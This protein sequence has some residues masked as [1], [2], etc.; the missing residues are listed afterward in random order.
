MSNEGPS[1]VNFN[2]LQQQLADTLNPTT[3]KQQAKEIFANLL[4]GMGVPYFTERLKSKL[5]EDLMTKLTELMKDPDNLGKN[6]MEFAKKVF[7]EKFLEP[8]KNALLD[9][10]S[11]FIPELKDIDL[12]KASLT[13]IQ[14]A[15][16]KGIITKMKAK[17]PPEI[18]DALPENFTRDDIL[19]AVKGLAQD[20]ALE[21]A[22]NNLPPEAYA[23]LER[24][25]DILTDPAKISDFV[26]GKLADVESTVKDNFTAVKNQVQSR[27]DDVKAAIKGKIDEATEGLNGKLD[28]LRSARDTAKSNW[29]DLKSQFSDQFK[30]AKAKLEQYKA[31]NP[32][33]TAEDLNPFENEIAQVKQNAAVARD[34]FLR[35]DVDF[36]SQLEATQSQIDDVTTNLVNKVS[37]IRAVVGQKVQAIAQK[38]QQAAEDVAQV[39]EAVASQ[40]EQRT[41]EVTQRA[42]TMFRS[43]E[44]AVQEGEGFFSRAKSF[45][46]PAVSKFSEVMGKLRQPAGTATGG[47]DFEGNIQML[48][49]DAPESRFAAGTISKLI[50]RPSLATYYGSELDNPAGLLSMEGN[51]VTIGRYKPASRVKKTAAERQQAPVEE[52]TQIAPKPVQTQGVRGETATGQ[53]EANAFM[54][55]QAQLAQQ[56]AKPSEIQPAPEQPSAPIVEQGVAANVEQQAPKA[57]TAT[58]T[59]GSESAPT[60][61]ATGETTEQVIAKTTE[62]AVAKTATSEAIEGSVIAGT[63]AIPVL[64][65][66]VDIGGILGSI[67]GAKALMGQK[68]PL[69]PTVSGE[70]YEPNL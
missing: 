37:D 9:K 50:E 17:L 41:T 56:Q 27:I 24:N 11:E 39:P 21:F 30:G 45:F 33:Y 18:A 23:E 15:V 61:A 22:K 16:S 12:A 2:E 3:A 32:N 54:E 10:A 55:R 13:D 5:P 52:E 66:L 68:A 60:A 57:T 48:S 20:K 29:T 26:K 36:A 35:N 44:E 53:Q 64:D 58:A 4:L 59:E 8:V 7:Q 28:E 63:E 40:V 70:T 42:S 6:A 31:D 46:E 47:T 43:G 51:R 62:E 67:F 65:V 34:N 1:L 19:T 25:Q 49:P 14:N 69:P 38:T